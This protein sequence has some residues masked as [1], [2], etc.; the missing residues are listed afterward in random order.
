MTTAAKVALGTALLVMAASSREARAQAADRCEVIV[1]PAAGRTIPANAPAL[2]YVVEAIGS[3]IPQEA[4]AAPVGIQ[5]FNAAG[6]TVP[7]TVNDDPFYG[8]RIEPGT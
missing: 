6:A 8:Y 4:Y 2:H 7:V 1:T 5:L 3:N